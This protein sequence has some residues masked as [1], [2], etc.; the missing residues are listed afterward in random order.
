MFMLASARLG[1]GEAHSALSHV[2]YYGLGVEKNCPS[3][4]IYLISAARKCKKI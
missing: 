1:N 3:S 4:R 2:F